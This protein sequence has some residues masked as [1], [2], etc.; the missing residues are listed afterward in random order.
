MV[1][2]GRSGLLTPPGDAAALAGA[3]AQVAGDPGLRRSMGDASLRLFDR[4]YRAA[5]M[6]ENVERVYLQNVSRHR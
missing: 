6:A 1:E 2:Q 3:L 5:L 4:Q